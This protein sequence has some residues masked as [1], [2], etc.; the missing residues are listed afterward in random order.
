VPG[1]RVAALREALAPHIRAN[2]LGT[3]LT[4][5]TMPGVPDVY[6]GT[7]SEYLALVDP[8]NRRPVRFPPADTAT[9][10]EG[11]R[12]EGAGMKG[13]VTAAALR[14]RRRYPDAFG[15][16]ATYQ[17]LPA[18]G[19][20]AA[21]LLAFARSGRV[22]TAVTRLSLRL[23][24]AGGWEDTQMALPPGRW[25]D[26][27]DPG[28]EFMGHVR[29]AELFERLPVALLERLGRD[30]EQGHGRAAPP[31]GPVPTRGRA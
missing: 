3:A 8:D 18:E 25:V 31:R 30:P 17:P 1:G 15:A 22:V 28:R 11:A 13:A 23:A 20:A 29:V 2:V 6:Q 14:L 27:V 5:L 19:R 26:A 16:A 24:E 7:E 12:M 21:H 10:T 4:Q 9:G